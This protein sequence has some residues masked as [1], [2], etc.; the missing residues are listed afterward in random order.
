MSLWTLLKLIAAL[1]V[2]AVMSFTAIFA[3]HVFVAPL[4]G[5]FADLIPTPVRVAAAPDDA[6]LAKVLDAAEM[7]DIDPG[8]KTFQKAHELLALGQLPAAREKLTAIVN[9]FPSS[10][11]APV[12]RRIV[13]EM[14]LDE[15]LSSAH[16]QGKQTHVVKRND[17]FLGIAA[18]YQTN[19]D[20]I[21][22][23]NDM[24][25]TRRIQ[26]GDELLV[27]PLNFRLLIEPRRNALSLWDGGRFVRE[28]AILHFG[29]PATPRKTSIAA[30]SAEAN[31]HRVT[32]QSKDY[33]DADKSIQLAKP[34]TSIRGWNGSG[35]K[36]TAG[37]ILRS[38]D[39][40]ELNLLT[41]PGNEAEIR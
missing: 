21:L 35:D 20:M 13:G 29:G 26:P 36:P 6:E 25:E 7:P 4:G 30:K 17:S 16:S 11:A 12:A 31:G 3:Y 38:H 5:I 8:E 14:N 9:V 10:S 22:H 15:I 24:M 1:V 37:I 33:R 2:M 19:M 18:R 23:L 27:M 41:R 28:Y 40:E 32:P 39:M 34:N